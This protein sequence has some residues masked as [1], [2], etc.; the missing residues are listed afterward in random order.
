MAGCCEAS[1]VADALRE[2]QRGTLQAVL[3]INAAVFGVIVVGAQL[4][5]SAAL[6]AGSLD[7]RGGAVTDGLF[8]SGSKP[9]KASHRGRCGTT[10]PATVRM[11]WALRVAR[12]RS[13]D[14]PYMLALNPL[15][16]SP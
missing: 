14:R 8:Q 2:K 4:A 9:S 12:P 6:F 11:R 15:P 10:W 3:V 1:C 5:G 16:P 13:A 7:N